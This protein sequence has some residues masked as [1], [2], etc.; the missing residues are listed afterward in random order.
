MQGTYM[1][2]VPSAT[3]WRTL[4]ESWLGVAV[5]ST[6]MHYDAQRRYSKRYRWVGGTATVLTTVIMAAVVREIGGASA[7]PWFR[8]GLAMAAVLATILT[9]LNAS[10]GYADRSAGHRTTGAGYAAVRRRID[11]ELTFDR[12]SI[13][14]QRWIAASIRTSLDALSHDAPEVPADI[15]AKHRQPPETSG[16]AAN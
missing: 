11:E 7:N 12:T 8:W 3:G 5:S 4:L 10:S 6:R 15:L 13:E 1:S 14:E 2:D 9:A 16:G